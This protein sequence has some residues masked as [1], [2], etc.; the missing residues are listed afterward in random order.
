MKNKTMKKLN[1][2]LGCLVLTL[3]LSVNVLNLNSTSLTKAPIHIDENS[4]YA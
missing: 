1:L 4:P 2:V 3:S